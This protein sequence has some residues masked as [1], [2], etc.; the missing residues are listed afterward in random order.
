MRSIYATIIFLFM[1]S[2]AKLF[3]QAD[4]FTIQWRVVASLPSSSKQVHP[5]IAGAVA[6]V[7]GERMFIGGGANFPDKMPWDGGAKQYHDELYIYDASYAIQKGYYHLPEKIAYTANCATPLGVF[8]AGGENEQGISSKAYILR[9]SDAQQ[10]PIFTALPNLPVALTNASAVY[11]DEL[12]YVIGGEMKDAVSDKVWCLDLRHRSLGWDNITRLPKPVSHAVVVAVEKQIFV[13]GGRKKN[14]GAISSL[15]DAVYSFDL[16]HNVWTD[17]PPLPYALSAGTGLVKNK[18]I[19]L[20]GGDKGTVFS[21]V[22]ALLLAIA[23]EQDADKKAALV[24]QKNDLQKQHPGFSSDILYYALPTGKTSV[25]SVLPY[26]TPVTTMALWWNNMIILP[27]GEVKAGIRT[28]L[29]LAG[30]L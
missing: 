15:Y 22:E 20:F 23:Q 4:S 18:G 12:I 19:L 17:H 25:V 5:G 29:I 1:F 2:V 8:F 28:P 26:P 11:I 3:A 6:G 27:S 30:K 7:D 9:W 21:K 13:L 16:Y 14:I 24:Q 10:K